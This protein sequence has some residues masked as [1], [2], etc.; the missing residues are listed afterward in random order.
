MSAKASPL[1]QGACL[2]RRHLAIKSFAATIAFVLAG[3]IGSSVTGAQTAG[4][5]ANRSSGSQQEMTPAKNLAK[6]TSE[7]PGAVPGAKYVGADTCKTCHDE[8]YTKH[9]ENTPHF[10]LLQGHAHG[11]EDCHGP[12]SAHVDSAGDPTK[13]VRFSQLS[14]AQASQRCLECHE[15]NLENVNFSGSVHLRNGVGCLACH[16]PHHATEPD[17]LLKN[18]QTLLCYGCHATQKAEFERPYRH[19]VNVGLIQCSDCHNPHGTFVDRQLRTAAGQFPICTNCHAETMGPFAFE[20]VPVRQEG[21]TACHTP[22]GSTNPRL[23]RVSQVNLLCMQCH[24]PTAN[25]NVPGIPSFHTQNAKYQACTM[26]H[27]QIHGS[28]FDE[29]FFR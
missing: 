20:H 25:S 21:C 15:T 7:M 18:Q 23:L 17:H 10:A 6:R 1:F 24:T 14:P 27:T 28:N 3:S 13:I 8:I 16:S 9:F 11:C 5:N 29:F 26:C 19:R 2:P 12:G 4:Q 22:H